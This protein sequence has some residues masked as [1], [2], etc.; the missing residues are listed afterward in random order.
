ML[1]F[2]LCVTNLSGLFK[3]IQ[4]KR[5]LPQAFHSILYTGPNSIYAPIISSGSIQNAQVLGCLAGVISSCSPFKA[6]FILFNNIFKNGIYI[7]AQAQIIQDTQICLP[8]KNIVFIKKKDHIQE[9]AK[10]KN[11][12]EGH[13][14]R[15][16]SNF[17]DCY[18]TFFALSCV[19]A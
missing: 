4:D 14:I 12:K 13:M 9:N 15:N 7:K 11:L 1:T 18:S 10:G 6:E 2:F 16:R 8:I 19:K 5:A 3:Q 17:I